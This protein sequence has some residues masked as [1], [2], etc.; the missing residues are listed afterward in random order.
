MIVTIHSDNSI[1]VGSIVTGYAVV[2]SVTGTQVL[3]WSNNGLPR[4]VDLGERVLMPKDRYTLS[5]DAGTEEFAADFLKVWTDHKNNS[6][7][8]RSEPEFAVSPIEVMLEDGLI[9]ARDAND[10]RLFS[11]MGLPDDA[12]GDYGNWS[13]WDGGLRLTPEQVAEIESAVE[14]WEKIREANQ[15]VR[16]WKARREGNIDDSIA[17]AVYA[18]DDRYPGGWGMDTFRACV[19]MIE[20]GVSTS[21]AADD[22][23]EFGIDLRRARTAPQGLVGTKRR[24]NPK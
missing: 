22:A 9:S 4:P 1:S 8:A 6:P 17:S 5:T 15:R 19:A 12:H 10:V 23:A 13:E 18:L 14:L 24:G 2:Q 20:E 16:A 21:R 7:Y 3:A 11:Q